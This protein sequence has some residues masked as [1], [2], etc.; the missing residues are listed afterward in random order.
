MEEIKLNSPKKLNLD[1]NAPEIIIEGL[2]LRKDQSSNSKKQENEEDDYVE[3]SYSPSKYFGKRPSFEFKNLKNI[4]KPSLNRQFSEAFFLRQEKQEKEE[5]LKVKFV[6]EV[7]I[8]DQINND[9]FKKEKNTKKKTILKK[10]HF[11][12]ELKL[13][14]IFDKDDCAEI[15]NKIKQQ[16]EEEKRDFKEILKIN[17]FEYW[18]QHHKNNDEIIKFLKVFFFFLLFFSNYLRV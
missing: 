5:N 8:G 11:V 4:E 10:T 13:E 7:L 17:F 9:P 16:S 1:S 18:D 12:E 6:G 3:R 15:I 14:D 2:K